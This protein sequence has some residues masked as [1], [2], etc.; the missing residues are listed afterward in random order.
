MYVCVYL[1]GKKLKKTIA[2]EKNSGGISPARN[3]LIS[4]QTAD[5]YGTTD[6]L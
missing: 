5:V 4:K 2:F 1:K 6:T 3:N